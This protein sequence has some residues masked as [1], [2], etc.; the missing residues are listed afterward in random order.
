MKS[1]V[2]HDNQAWYD[3]APEVLKSDTW[4]FDIAVSTYRDRG[5]GMKSDK[6]VTQM[7]Y[8]CPIVGVLRQ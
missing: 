5:F 6:W 8:G 1:R 7:I 4:T 2:S 3:N